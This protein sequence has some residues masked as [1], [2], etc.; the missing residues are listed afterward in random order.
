MKWES[1]R[2][3]KKDENEKMPP[4]DITAAEILSNTVRAKSLYKDRRL[5][6]TG[7]ITKIS[8]DS[9]ISLGVSIILD[10]GFL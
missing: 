2:K 10:Y 1:E 5:N 8:G 4:V 3:R 6:V 7:T 9:S